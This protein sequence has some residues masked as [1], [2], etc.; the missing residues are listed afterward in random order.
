MQT[1]FQLVTVLIPG[2]WKKLQKVALGTVPQVPWIFCLINM[3]NTE[4]KKTLILYLLLSTGQWHRSTKAV[5]LHVLCSEKKMLGENDQLFLLIVSQRCIWP[6][7]RPGFIAGGVGR[8]P[9][10]ACSSTQS[11]LCLHRAKLPR[12]CLVRM[13]GNS[14]KS[15]NWQQIQVS[16]WV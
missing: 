6:E 1:L 15:P 8:Q 10:S 14:L 9:S 3:W 16:H 13:L 11:P 7:G 2:Q 4:K 12:V 5:V